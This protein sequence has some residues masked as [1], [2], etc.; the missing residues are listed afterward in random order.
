[1]LLVL[2]MNTAAMLRASDNNSNTAASRL[3]SSSVGSN[4]SMRDVRQ[5]LDN[6]QGIAWQGQQ[7]VLRLQVQLQAG[8]AAA[9]GKADRVAKLR[10]ELAAASAAGI[11]SSTVQQHLAD[12]EAA[13]AAATQEVDALQQQLCAAGATTGRS[14]KTAQALKQQEKQQ[15]KQQDAF[16]ERL[17]RQQEQR[18]AAVA[19][20]GDSQAATASTL[21]LPA[22]PGSQAARHA[23]A[24]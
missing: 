6:T 7:E 12:L 4:R 10:R 1:M 3:S 19:P 11:R 14:C 18:T 5:Q 23:Q 24:C 20:A 15:E 17:K 21:H 13:A 2:R 9:A 8:K 16:L 22:G